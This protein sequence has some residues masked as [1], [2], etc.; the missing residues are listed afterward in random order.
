[1]EKKKNQSYDQPRQ[2]IKQQRHYFADK[3]PSSQSCGFTSIAFITE[4]IIIQWLKYKKKQNY[5]KNMDTFF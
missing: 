5:I 4:W 2:Y 1:M 3:G